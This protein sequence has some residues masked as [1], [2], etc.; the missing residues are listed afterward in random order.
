MVGEILTQLLV[1]VDGLLLADL[2]TL[3]LLGGEL[4]FVAVNHGCRIGS[5]VGLC[6]RKN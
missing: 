1:F 3:G 5:V 2:E 4:V 6:R